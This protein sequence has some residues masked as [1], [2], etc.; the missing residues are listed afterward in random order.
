[1]SDGNAASMDAATSDTAIRP[2]AAPLHGVRRHRW[3]MLRDPVARVRTVDVL[4]VLVAASLPWSTTAVAIVMVL[5]F[6]ALIPTLD[7]RDFVQ[8][9]RRP[10]S[11]LPLVFFALA[12]I[13]TLW[14]DSAWAARLHGINPVA[15]LLAIPFLLYH[16]ERSQRGLWVLVAFFV[17]CTA[18][19]LLSWLVYVVPF[20]PTSRIAPGVP[21]KNYIDQS[22]EFVLCMFALALPALTWLRERRTALVVASALLILGF[23]A[24][25]MFVVSARTALVYMPVL[26]VLFG[27][28]HLSRRATLLL[29][30]AA[31]AVGAVIWSTSPYL[32]TRVTNIAV[33]YDDY[34][35]NEVASTAQRLE[36]WR[37][38]L[39]FIANAPV[40]GNGTGST[41]ELFERDAV[42]QHGLLAEV[43]GN[44]HNQT[45]NVAVQWGLLGCIVLYAMWLF[46][47]LLFRGDG[48]AAWVGLLVVVQNM[49]SS[50]L[51]SHLFDFHEGWMYVL[52]VGV[53]GGMVLRQRACGQTDAP[54]APPIPRPR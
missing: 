12:V 20:T 29:V 16:F 28:T 30:L 50:L 36:Y 18:L 8:S 35:H 43:I 31:V 42:G 48:L 38:S 54:S 49:V 19:M 7:W 41:K 46:H 17:S 25:M 10:A 4:A 34:Q 15:K 51:N 11:A 27:L 44:P 40:F 33:E 45:L 52:G 5:W 22:Q 13:G 6:L 47:L 23:F 9:L 2:D 37:K 21:V 3:H 32:R 24:N 26:L 39:K 1:M 53:A 14:S